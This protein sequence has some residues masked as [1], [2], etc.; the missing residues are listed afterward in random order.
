L[1]TVKFIVWQC[2]IHYVLEVHQIPFSLPSFL[3]GLIN[4]KTSN[5]AWATCSPVFFLDSNFNFFIRSF[6]KFPKK[7]VVVENVV[8]YPRVNFHIEIPYTLPSVKI[9]KS[10]KMI[11]FRF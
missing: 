5:V 6:R 4:P 8:I 11:K 7:Y 10:H 1:K 3:I 9:T 2:F